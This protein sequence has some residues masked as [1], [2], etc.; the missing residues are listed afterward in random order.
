MIV[1]GALPVARGVARSADDTL[2]LKVIHELMCNF[3][4]DTAAIER[5]FG[6]EFDSYFA[7]D[8]ALLREHEQEGMVRVT[9]ARIE[10]T[11]VGQL[12]V[13]NLAMCFD[14]Y[15]REKHAASVRPVFSRTV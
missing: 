12:F 4:I 6:I 13:R 3:R 11:P 5:E 8:L 7:D 15:Q 1:A 10:A 9:P 2:R 14:R